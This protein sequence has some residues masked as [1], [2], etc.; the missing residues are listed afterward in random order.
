MGASSFDLRGAVGGLPGKAQ[1]GGYAGDFNARVKRREEEAKKFNEPTDAE[2]AQ[3]AQDVK[4]AEQKARVQAEKEHGNQKS[5]L[6]TAVLTAAQAQ[7]DAASAQDKATKELTQAEQNIKNLELQNKQG[8]PEMAGA[9]EERKAKKL[10]SDFHVAIKENADKELNMTTA[11]LSKINDTIQKR[12]KELTPKPPEINNRKIYANA[13]ES[14]WTNKSRLGIWIP[15]ADKKAAAK[16]RKGKS[17]EKKLFDEI[18]EIME[19]EEGGGHG[20][21]QK[22]KPKDGS[23]KESAKKDTSGGEHAAPH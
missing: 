15:A 3:H 12:A 2:K 20:D 21:N 10:A 13:L 14:G 17:K 5:S 4:E 19:Q 7:K 22:E 8:T 23:K 18:K 6:E 16:I 9:I 1:K 11:N